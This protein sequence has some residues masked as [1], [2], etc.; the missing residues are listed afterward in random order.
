MQEGR[1]RRRRRFGGCTSSSP[2]P[3]QESYKLVADF[4]K[5]RFGVSMDDMSLF[6]LVIDTGK[7]RPDA[8]VQCLADAAWALPA[9]DDAAPSAA[10]LEVDP[11]VAR[12]VAREIER[13]ARRSE[14]KH[15]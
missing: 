10:A 15:G 8:V 5:T 2:P 6:D 3:R 4:A 13:Q 9:G 12:A 14:G 1:S 11:F 7:V